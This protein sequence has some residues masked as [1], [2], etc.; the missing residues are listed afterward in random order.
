MNRTSTTKTK[1]K[2]LKCIIKT[3]IRASQG[4]EKNP[5][6]SYSNPQLGEGHKHMDFF[7]LRIKGF[8]L[9]IRNLL[10]RDEPSD[11]WI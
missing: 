6:S 3:E 1:R 9:H 5:H 2:A 8:E 4:G 11:I 7:N 10:K